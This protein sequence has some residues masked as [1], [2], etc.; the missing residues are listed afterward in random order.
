MFDRIG[1]RWLDAAALPDRRVLRTCNTPA[2]YEAAVAE[3]RAAS[4]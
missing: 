1:A 4:G 2:E 3:D